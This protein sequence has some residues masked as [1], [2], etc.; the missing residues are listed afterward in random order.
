M[1]FAISVDPEACGLS[2]KGPCGGAALPL[3]REEHELGAGQRTQFQRFSI[4]KTA[5]RD[6]ERAVSSK[7]TDRI[8]S[9]LP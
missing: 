5:S 7:S 2:G 3:R 9:T 6:S 8:S 1:A 4:S